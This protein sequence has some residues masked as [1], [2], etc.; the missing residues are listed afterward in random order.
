AVLEGR[1][2]ALG[3]PAC[4]DAF[5]VEDLRG[6]RITQSSRLEGRPRVE[7]VRGQPCGPHPVE[8]EAPLRVTR[9]VPR[10]DA[11]VRQLAL[12]RVRLDN[13][14]GPGLLAFLLVF[15]LD[16]AALADSFGQRRDEV[17]LDLAF[18]GPRRLGELELAEGLFE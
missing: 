13:A 10:V 6:P 9:A 12:E 1:R 11:P 14:L 4:R 3:R 15:D 2:P 7:A 17:G 8:P 5:Q 18:L 16:Q